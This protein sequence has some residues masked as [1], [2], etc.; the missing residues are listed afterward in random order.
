MEK[1]K[2]FRGRC[3]WALCCVSAQ[4]STASRA[5]DTISH[6]PSWSLFVKASRAQ[7]IPDAMSLLEGRESSSAGQNL[8]PQGRFRANR[9]P[10]PA[11]FWLSRMLSA[12]ADSSSPISREDTTHRDPTPFNELCNPLGHKVVWNKSNNTQLVKD[13]FLSN[14]FKLILEHTKHKFY[15]LKTIKSP[16]NNVVA[17]PVF[18]KSGKEAEFFSIFLLMWV[19]ETESVS[20][21][22]SWRERSTSPG[23][24]VCVC[25]FKS[26]ERKC[27][28]Q[29][30]AVKFLCSSLSFSSYLKFNSSG[31]ISPSTTTTSSSGKSVNPH[32]S[33]IPPLYNRSSHS[34]A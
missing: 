15:K 23:L 29:I 18:T 28:T 8:Q 25:L 10:F 24:K 22:S 5:G 1:H 14:A 13:F 34:S 4:L 12:V 20:M 32:P 11:L 6:K 7:T 9:T 3:S 19:E 31:S 33:K 17:F 16:W 30:S 21:K 26:L 27:F 2:P